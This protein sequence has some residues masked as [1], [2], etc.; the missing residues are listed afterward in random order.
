MSKRLNTNFNLLAPAPLD[1]RTQVSTYAG[2]ATIP[3]VFIGLKVYVVD[4][5]KEYRYYSTG[6]VEWSTTSSGGDGV[7]GSITGIL[8]DQTD[9]VAALD[10]KFDKVGGIITGQTTVEDL[11][12]AENFQIQ[13]SFASTESPWVASVLLGEPVGSSKVLNAVFISQA[14]YDQAV[15][16][17]TLVAG[18]HYIIT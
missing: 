6:W 13:G 3:I 11:V 17:A 9:L 12:I 15:I 10:L 16:D 4:V 2:L 18:T 14:D 7:W 8:T 5:D 1:A